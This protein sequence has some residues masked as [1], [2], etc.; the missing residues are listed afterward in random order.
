MAS[1]TR[2]I[3][4][5][6]SIS[7]APGPGSSGGGS[8][9]SQHPRAQ[10]EKSDT[11]SSQ[12][13]STPSASSSS[14]QPSSPEATDLSILVRN[15]FPGPNIHNIT[16]F[17]T[18]NF[19]TALEKTFPTPIA[20]TLMKSTRSLLVD[21]ISKVQREALDLKDLDNVRLYI[22]CHPKTY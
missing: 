6:A 16:P 14:P 2:S 1:R 8:S 10:L 19:F 17:H 22:S 9:S 13:P 12:S 3:S 21:R 18:Y 4:S 20:R 11:E 7:A 15:S 5:Q